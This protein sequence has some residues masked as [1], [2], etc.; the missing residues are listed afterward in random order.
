M[1]PR[2]LDEMGDFC[3]EEER[4]E[5]WM[6]SPQAPKDPA[7]ITRIFAFKKNPNRQVGERTNFVE[8]LY[9]ASDLKTNIEGETSFSFDLSDSVTSYR[10]MIGKLLNY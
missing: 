5:I 6:H 3:F 4:N 10:I 2:M 9:W 7:L 8:T 1:A